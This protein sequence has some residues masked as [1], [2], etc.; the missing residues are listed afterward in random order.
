MNSFVIR[1][2]YRKP[3]VVTK[4]SGMNESDAS[5]ESGAEDVMSVHSSDPDTNVLP[6]G[7][8]TILIHLADSDDHGYI[9]KF[10]CYGFCY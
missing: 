5:S 10:L 4:H 3:A 8:T 7:A 9:I 1:Y 2:L 6:K